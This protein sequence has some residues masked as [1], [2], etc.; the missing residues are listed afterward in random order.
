MPQQD[1]RQFHRRRRALLEDI[2]EQA[3][4]ALRSSQFI[5]HMNVARAKEWNSSTLSATSAP[6]STSTAVAADHVRSD[7]HARRRTVDAVPQRRQDRGVVLASGAGR[8]HAGNPPAQYLG[9][10]GTVFKRG[11]TM[12]IPYAYADLRFNP[13]FDKQTGFFTRSILCAW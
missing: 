12:N 13:S 9:I 11:N 10:A 2:A 7:A 5:E 6:S 4:P 8:R 1:R 3:I